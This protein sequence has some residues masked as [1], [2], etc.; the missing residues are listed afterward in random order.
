V[1]GACEGSGEPPEIQ[2]FWRKG[3]RVSSGGAIVQGDAEGQLLGPGLIEGVEIGHGWLRRQEPHGDG[4]VGLAVFSVGGISII[5]DG[6]VRRGL[7]K[8]PT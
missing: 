1:L 5:P 4:A 3:A 6:L 2:F 7:T 8:R